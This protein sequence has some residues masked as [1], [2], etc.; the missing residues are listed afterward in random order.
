MEKGAGKES[1]PQVVVSV[2]QKNIKDDE[3]VLLKGGD[4]NRLKNA[5]RLKTDT[6]DINRIQ[7]VLSGVPGDFSGAEQGQTA[8]Y[9]ADFSR[10]RLRSQGEDI[11]AVGNLHV[12]IPKDLMADAVEVYG[13]DWQ[14]FVWNHRLQRPTPERLQWLDESSV[15]IGPVLK[16]STA[17]IEKYANNV[18]DHTLL[19]PL[20][21]IAGETASQHFVK[22][23][24][25]MAQVN[26]REHFCLETLDTLSQ[27]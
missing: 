13:E 21:L 23:T 12:A 2:A 18:K 15:I 26:A 22:G 20:E 8:Y 6:K 11:I 9:Y 14:E 5:I 4:C 1:E 24:P 25:I 3:F 10:A 19:E 27:K 17:T 16:C 7:N